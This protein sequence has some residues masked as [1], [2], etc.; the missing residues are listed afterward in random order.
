MSRVIDQRREA[1][2]AALESGDA[3]AYAELVTE[4]VVWMP[5]HGAALVGRQAFRS[6]LGPFLDAYEY[7][8]SVDGVSTRETERW[9]AET[10]VFNSRM[11]PRG[12]GSPATHSG[13]YLLLWRHD[14]GVWRIERYVDLGS[15]EAA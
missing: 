7:E 15:L 13:R 10:G 5:P 11:T 12:G 2:I 9:I 6:W 8:F 4:D 3:D 1:W 14:R